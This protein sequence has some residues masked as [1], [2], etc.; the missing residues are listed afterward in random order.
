[1]REE[2]IWFW[3]VHRCPIWGTHTSRARMTE[4]QARKAYPNLHI[5]RVEP[6]LMV[7]QVAETAAELAERLPGRRPTQ[8]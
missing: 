6:S 8:G 1:M 4:E 5:E 2:K 7:I 3:K